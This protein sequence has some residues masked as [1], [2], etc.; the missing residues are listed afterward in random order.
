MGT[1]GR[2]YW[3]APDASVSCDLRALPFNSL[4]FCTAL[5]TAAATRI[6]MSHRGISCSER[7]NGNPEFVPAKQARS[8][9]GVQLDSVGVEFTSGVRPD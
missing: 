1:S 3:G 9:I 2:F 4:G 6:L 7:D 5:R 8:V